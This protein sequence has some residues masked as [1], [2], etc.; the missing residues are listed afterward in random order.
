MTQV[1][2]KGNTKA[3]RSEGL[4]IDLDAQEWGDEIGRELLKHVKESI[5]AGLSPNGASN[6]PLDP[7]GNQ[8]R[9]AARGERPRARGFTSERKFIDSLICV[10]D[11]ANKKTATYYVT[12]DREGTFKGWLDREKRLAGV[13][14]FD[15]GN[16]VP[17][18]IA[19]VVKR[20]MKDAIK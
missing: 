17:T 10:K 9:R 7:D 8:G 14:Y 1:V 3:W 13:D 19:K 6:P 12:T 4:T 2:P 15:L 20:L 18:V 16:K 5:M 11:T